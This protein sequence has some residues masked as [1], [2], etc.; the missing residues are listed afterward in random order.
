MSPDKPLV[1][2]GN[3][4]IQNT[5]APT[6]NGFTAGSTVELDVGGSYS[7][8]GIQVRGTYTGALTVQITLDG[9]LWVTLSGAMLLTN[10]ITGAQS[11]T[12]SSASQGV[13]ALNTAG[14]VGVRVTALAAVT[15]NAAVTLVGGVGDGVVMLGSSLPAGSSVLGAI[16]NVIPG[17]GATNLGKAEDAAAA[18][19]D[20][21]VFVL[22]VRRDAPTISA[23][24]TGD[25]SEIAVGSQGQ[26]FTQAI[27]AAKRTYSAAVKF[28][29]VVGTVFEIYGAASTTVEINRIT[30]TLFGTAAGKM[31]FVVA[32]RSAIA[33]GG[34]AVA[35]TRVPYNAADAAAASTVRHFTAAPTAGALVGNVRYGMVWTG[36]SIPSDR[37]KIE[38]GA[39]AKSFTLT[40]ATQAIT[41]DLAGSVPAGAEF[42][43][44]IEW[45]EY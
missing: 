16:T 26:V 4:T 18:S 5:G 42:V 28:T 13:W 9:D 34:T 19:G 44:D 3:I 35:S 29:P 30:L 32:K 12:I 8:T 23:S 21:G 22:G 33:T 15:G 2:T 38:S 17:T 14:V 27:D 37:V 45:T 10:M 39:Y 40:S 41:V 31:D 11:A 1:A 25:Y 24:A 43:L 6:G 36:A 7:S 20:T